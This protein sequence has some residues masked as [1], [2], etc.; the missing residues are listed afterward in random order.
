MDEVINDVQETEVNETPVE[1]PAG[2]VS[3]GDSVRAALEKSKVEIK[4]NSKT[5][6]E[7]IEK[8][9]KIRAEDG[10]FAKKEVTQTIEPEA[11][12][13]KTV[14]EQKPSI[15]APQSL[16]GELKEKFGE[17]P[18]EWQGEIDRLE[19]EAVKKIQ[20]TSQMANFGQSIQQEF[21]PYE[22]ML[23][24]AGATP[25]QALKSFL[26]T[27]YTLRTAPPA[28]KQAVAMNLLR[29]YGIELPGADAPQVDPNVAALYQEINNL[30]QERMQEAAQRTNAE[31]TQV[32]ST[33]EQFA[34]DPKHEYFTDVR[35][36]MGALIDSGAAKSLDDAYEQACW[37]NP[38]IRDQLIRTQQAEAE[39]KRK[40]DER[41]AVEAKKAAAVSVRGTPAS[42]I[43]PAVGKETVRQTIA[44]VAAQAQGRI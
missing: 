43:A 8:P 33:I 9:Q 7:S 21:A 22:A 2:R 16:K 27:E 10:K 6:S 3:V 37:A 24:Q 23:R 20:S 11:A 26:Q 35:Q 34:A 25:Q 40:A 42:P 31:N 4:T 30:K 1:A 17:L 32:Q 5:E 14:V 36:H 12:P 41:K 38:S 15:K 13:E 39:A 18:P 28:Q 44:R 19:R 29:H